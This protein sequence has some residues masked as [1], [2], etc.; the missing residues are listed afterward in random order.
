MAARTRKIAHDDETRAK[1]QAANIINRL[2]GNVMGEVDLSPAQVSSAKTLLNK[3][4]PD[5]QAITIGGE[6]ED[7]SIRITQTIERRIVR[8]R[9]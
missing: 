7:G 3:V 8:P 4:L 1:I 6:E 2:Y 9:D 5:L